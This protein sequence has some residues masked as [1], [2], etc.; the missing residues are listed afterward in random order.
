M[1]WPLNLKFSGHHRVV[2]GY[3][4]IALLNRISSFKC[5][6]TS[7]SDSQNQ[8]GTSQCLVI[9]SDGDKLQQNFVRTDVTQNLAGLS[10]VVLP[11]RRGRVEPE[12]GW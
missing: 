7:S 10:T 11:R 8:S 2:F 3:V 4:L 1:R 12:K 5:I 6:G 9:D